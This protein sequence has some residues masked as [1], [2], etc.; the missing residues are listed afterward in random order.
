MT[1]EEE[2]V[3]GYRRLSQADRF[4]EDHARTQSMDNPTLNRAAS[5]P[6]RLE[7][8]DTAA[9]VRLSEA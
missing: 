1:M 5:S 6:R 9:S 2:K 4:I 7:N 8:S 3:V